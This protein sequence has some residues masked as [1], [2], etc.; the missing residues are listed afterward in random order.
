MID[1]PVK[2]EVRISWP[3]GILAG[4]LVFV[5]SEPLPGPVT[6]IRISL[7][8]PGP[9]HPP[10]PVASTVLVLDSPGPRRF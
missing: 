7:D 10:G 5:P 2:V 9:R 8:P 4:T 3:A 6:S 1:G